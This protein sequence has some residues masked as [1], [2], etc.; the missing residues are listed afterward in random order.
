MHHKDLTGVTYREDS[1][2]VALGPHVGVM[3][4]LQNHPCLIMFP[5]LKRQHSDITFPMNILV[6]AYYFVALL[7]IK[8]AAGGMKGSQ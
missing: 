7:E 1:L 8:V 2:W 3:D 4:L 5:V 6:R